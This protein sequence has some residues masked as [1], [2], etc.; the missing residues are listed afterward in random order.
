MP[1]YIPKDVALGSMRVRSGLSEV[2]QSPVTR[3]YPSYIA[4]QRIGVLTFFG[5][6]VIEESL[7]VT[8]LVDKKRWF[9]GGGCEWVDARQNLLLGS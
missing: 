7:A 3:H 4:R 6:G 1:L 2:S 9:R 8:H 5:M